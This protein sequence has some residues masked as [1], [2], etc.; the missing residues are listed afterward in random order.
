VNF[1]DYADF[2]DDWRWS[3]QAGGYNNSD[4]NCNGSVD[5]YDLDI[6]AEQWLSSC[7]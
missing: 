5:F 1:I 3:G 2:A 4:L 7:P 6:F